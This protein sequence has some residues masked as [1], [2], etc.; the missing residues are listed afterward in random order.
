M[1][2]DDNVLTFLSAFWQTMSREWPGVD[3]LRMDKFLYLVRQYV[4]ASFVWL[5]Q[6][7]AWGS[8]AGKKEPQAVRDRYLAMLMD[9]GAPFAARDPKVPVGLRLHVLDVWVDELDKVDERR[10][11][12]VQ[13]LMEP[14]RKLGKETVIKSVR[15]RVGEVLE[16]ERLADWKNE[17][18][19]DE[20]EDED[21]DDQ[22]DEND[23]KAAQNGEDEEFGGF[24][25]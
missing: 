9:E 1:R 5:S 17:A 2:S 3:R 23:N 14:L 22:D 24:D 19:D 10:D 12:P 8:V 16:D 13:E 15:E 20:A 11:A 7:T 21:D 18:V 6:K 4:N 25:D